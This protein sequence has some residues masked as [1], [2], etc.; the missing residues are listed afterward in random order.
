MTNEGRVPALSCALGLFAVGLGKGVEGEGIWTE[1]LLVTGSQ[2]GLSGA[3]CVGSVCVVC[4][5]GSGVQAR[6][7]VCDC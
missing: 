1:Y 2:V 7:N 6:E 4:L 5:S 3:G